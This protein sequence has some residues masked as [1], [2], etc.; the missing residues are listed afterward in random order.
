MKSQGFSPGVSSR[1]IKYH[2][3]GMI[4]EKKKKQRVSVSCLLYYQKQILCVLKPENCMVQARV[5]G[6]LL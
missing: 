6:R 5:P 1:T 2:L 4:L 3:E